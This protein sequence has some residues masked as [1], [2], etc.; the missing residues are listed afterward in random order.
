MLMQNLRKLY[1][2]NRFG[3]L[4][5]SIS[6]LSLLLTACTERSSLTIA[7][8]TRF[9]AELIDERSECLSFRRNFSTPARD[10]KVLKEFYEAAKAA[11]CLKPDV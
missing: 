11:H 10:E 8:K 4:F 2:S 9:Y 7:E 5:A 6:I 3:L 1:D